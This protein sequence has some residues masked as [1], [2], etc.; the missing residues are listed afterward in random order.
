MPRATLVLDPAF[1]V[2][3]VRRRTFGSFVEHLGRVRLQ[4]HP[5]PGPPDGRRRRVPRRRDRARPRARRLDRALPGRQLRLR[6]PLGGRHRAGRPSARPGSTSP[7]TRP[8]PTPSA[9][10]SSCGG[11]AKAGRR[12]DDG[13]STSARAAS[14]EAIDLLEYC[15]VRGGHARVRPA[16]ARTAPS[17]PHDIRMWCLGNEMDGPWQIGAQ[18]RHGVRPPR[19]RDGPGD[20]HGRPGPRARGLRVVRLRDADVRR[21]GARGARPR[22]TTQVDYISAH[23]YYWETDGD[24]A[25]LPRVARST[26]TT[27]STPWWRRR[28]RARAQAGTPS[29]STSRSTSG[30]SG[31]INDG[32]SQTPPDT[33]GPSRRVLLEDHYSVADAVVVGGLLISLLRHT[34]R[35]HAASLAQLVNVI[36]PIMT[37]PG[38]RVWKQTTFHPF[39]LT[40]RYAVG[41]VLAVRLETPRTSTPRSTATTPLVDAVATWDAEAGALSVFAVNRSV[42][43]ADDARASTCVPVRRAALVEALHDGRRRPVR[44]GR[45][46]TTT[47]RS[48]PGRTRRPAGRGR[49]AAGRA[50]AGVLVHGAPGP[51]TPRVGRGPSAAQGPAHRSSRMQPR[52]PRRPDHPD[53]RP[54]GPARRRRRSRGPGTRGPASRTRRACRRSRPSG[55]IAAGGRPRRGSRGRSPSRRRRSSARGR[56]PRSAASSRTAPAL[57]VPCSMSPTSRPV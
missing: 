9:S 10:T 49:S 6:L 34:D 15:N 26:W 24:L 30:T 23:A 8:S 4:R 56:G 40:S 2:A 31:T 3:P 41:D 17:E 22:R 36:A 29:G 32:E 19:R 25:Q 45:R 7:G 52:A 11:A 47:R 42:D 27:S 14:Q 55:L 37:E 28:R 1:R 57:A 44:Q 51:L 38:G 20:A 35:V 43:D 21:V 12:A 50:A 53:S 18:D 33:T 13:A 54:A 48:C 16:P 46:S 39:A 5:R